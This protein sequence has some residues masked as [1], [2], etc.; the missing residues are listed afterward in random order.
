MNS[1]QKERT[2]AL[3]M[4]DSCLI[5][6]SCTDYW[7][8]MQ[9]VAGKWS[10]PFERLVDA[11]MSPISV[12]KSMALA[13]FHLISASNRIIIKFPV[14][15]TTLLQNC[16]TKVKVSLFLRFNLET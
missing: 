4:D 3:A 13:F 6:R 16:V 7:I 1:K 10:S 15:A 5:T 2:K 14:I 12:T 8:R 9:F 11:P